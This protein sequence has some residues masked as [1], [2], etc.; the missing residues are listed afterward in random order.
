MT[1]NRI[2]LNQ[3]TLVIV[4]VDFLPYLHHPI[5]RKMR[6][7]LR[8]IEV[9]DPKKTFGLIKRQG[10]VGGKELCID[11]RR[12]ARIDPSIDRIGKDRLYDV[13]VGRPDR[14]RY[15]ISTGVGD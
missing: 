12:I 9:V 6:N 13:I 3:G 7:T 10:S 5:A 2:V 15:I 1:G 4:D 8:P 14:E 11:L